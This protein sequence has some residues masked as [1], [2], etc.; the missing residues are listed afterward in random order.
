M[1]KR[2]DELGVLDVGAVEPNAQETWKQTLV[3]PKMWQKI[4]S[5]LLGV[6]TGRSF[7]Q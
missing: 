5:K 4:F 1:L 3:H 6:F 2:P 7:D